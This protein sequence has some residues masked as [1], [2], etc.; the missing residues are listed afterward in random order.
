MTEVGRQ[1]WIV[2]GFMRV[3]DAVTD[4]PGLT[5]IFV[6]TLCIYAILFAGS[7]SVLR[8]LAAKPI[9]LGKDRESAQ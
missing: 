8:F 9:E 1:P 3:K 5:S 6:V 2:Y 7:I 4:A